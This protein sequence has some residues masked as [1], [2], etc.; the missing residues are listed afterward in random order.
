MYF[1]TLKKSRKLSGFVIYSHFKNMALKELGMWKG[2]H[3]SVNGIRKEHLFCQRWYIKGKGLDLG[4]EPPRRKR[5]PPPPPSPGV[6][7]EVAYCLFFS[8][9]SFIYFP[10]LSFAIVIF[11]ADKKVWGQTYK[12]HLETEVKIPFS[13]QYF[14]RNPSAHAQWYTSSSYFAT[15]VPLFMQ[16]SLE[17][18]VCFTVNFK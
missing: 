1:M 11:D 12:Q 13:S 7:K 5:T 18:G 6:F 17:H 9:P 8:P 4:A 10:L 14:P 2:Y 15:Q 3:F 16:G